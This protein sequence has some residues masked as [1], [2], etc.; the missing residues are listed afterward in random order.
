MSKLLILRIGLRKK[1]G[2]LGED[3]LSRDVSFIEVIKIVTNL[4]TNGW[5]KGN[6]LWGICVL[7]K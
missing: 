7:V 5:I 6:C 3:G 2:G 4:K 1:E